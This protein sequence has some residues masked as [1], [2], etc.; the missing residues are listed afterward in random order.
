[1]SNLVA[2]DT[3]AV[4]ALE[5]FGN[6]GQNSSIQYLK[7]DFKAGEFVYGQ[8]E[9]LVE[10]DELFAANIATLS[11]GYIC[12]E[13]GKP[14]GEV[15]LPIASGQSVSKADLED[16]PDSD[17]WQEQSSIEFQ[18]LETGETLLFKSSSGGGKSALSALSKEFI[19]RLKRGEHDTVPVVSMQ[20][21]GYKHNKFGKINTPKF[22]VDHWLSPADADAAGQGEEAEEVEVVEVETPKKA[23]RAT[24]KAKATEKLAV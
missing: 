24:R 2:F 5:Q 9:T 23:K 14:V 17:G 13:G 19:N 16:H 3:N 11:K 10:E 1:M 20:V 4:M 18:S 7:F 12:W 22:V 21:G 8:E 15:M 6:E